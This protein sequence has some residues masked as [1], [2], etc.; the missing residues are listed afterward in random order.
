MTSY[1]W[2]GQYNNRVSKA[3]TTENIIR[4]SK[5]DCTETGNEYRYCVRVS[6]IV[7]YKTRTV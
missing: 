1:T 2:T 6:S 3:N 4:M 7:F 5:T